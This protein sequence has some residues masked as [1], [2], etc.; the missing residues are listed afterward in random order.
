MFYRRKPNKSGTFSVEVVDKQSG[1]NIV[2]QRLDTS[3]DE[4]KKFKLYI[5]EKKI[6]YLVGNPDATIS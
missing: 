3:R 1:K 5:Y 6:V 4:Y 2:V